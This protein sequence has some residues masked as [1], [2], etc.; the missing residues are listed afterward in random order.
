MIELTNLYGLWV[1]LAIPVIIIIY[2]I[3]NKYTEQVIATTYIWNISE[4]FLKKKKPVSSLK[5]I[6]SLLLQMLAIVMIALTICQ[7]VIYTPNGAD[8]YVFVLDASASMQIENSGTS[9]FEVG[10]QEIAKII[11][12]APNGSTFTIVHAGESVSVICQ[13][14]ENPER[15]LTFLQTMEVEDSASSLTNAQNT[16]QELFVAQPFIKTYL[17]TDKSVDSVVNAEIISV[18]NTVENYSIIDAKSYLEDEKLYFSGKAISHQNDQTVQIALFI[19]DSTTPSK[20][21]SV[22]LKKGEETD[23]TIESPTT[24]FNRAT[25]QLT[26]SDSLSVDDTFVIYNDNGDATTHK[27]LIV[28]NNDFFLRES[29]EAMGFANIDTKLTTDTDIDLRGYGL[30]VF[31]SYVPDVMPNDGEVWFVNPTNKVNDLSSAK[32][33]VNA[34]Y[35]DLSAIQ[36]EYSKSTSSLTKRILANTSADDSFNELLGG[37]VCNTYLKGYSSCTYDG[38]FTPIMYCDNDP[39]LFLGENANRQRQVVFAF[40]FQRSDF[41]VQYDYMVILSNLIDYT[42]PEI[43]TERNFVVGDSVEINTL[44]NCDTIKLVTPS[45]EIVSIDDTNNLNTYV[46]SQAGEYTVEQRIGSEIKSSKLYVTL[47]KTECSVLPTEASFEI[48]GELSSER[49]PAKYEDLI[50]WFILL[51]VAFLID[52]GVYCYEQYQLR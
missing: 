52:W 51:A 4:Q 36:V 12:D 34:V 26:S 16:V 43:L 28:S 35:D 45:G 14:E 15:A 17:V 32:F 44:N 48:Q 18:A 13:S 22:Q 10:K 31:D 20:T 19:N 37:F 30:Y 42:F 7:P 39:V 49:L 3:K 29:F 38:N 24:L 2:L 47:N 46:L 5:S 40:D 33:S 8:S 9:R 41:V 25:L 6:L 27:I 11:S 23:F 1:L 21:V 50:A